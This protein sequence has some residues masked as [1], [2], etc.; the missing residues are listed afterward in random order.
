[1][2]EQASANE[3]QEGYFENSIKKYLSEYHLD[4]IQDQEFETH[5][6]ELTQDAINLFQAF[7]RAGMSTYEAMER[8]LTETLE[9]VTSPYSILK[10]FLLENQTFLTYATGIEDL[11]EQDLLMHILVENTS[12]ISALQMA[13]TP[14]DSV[15][16]NKDLLSGIRKT[17]LSLNKI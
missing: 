4:L 8:A 14:E 15:Q 7:D 17:L 3:H 11:D 1:M 9:R 16:A 12:T 5:L 13:T 6:S 2:I 10:E